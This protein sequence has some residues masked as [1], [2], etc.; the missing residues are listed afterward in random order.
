M[1]PGRISG[2]KDQPAKERFA[3]KLSA[4]E[5]QRG[6]QSESGGDGHGDG[7]N[8][9]AIQQRGPDGIV[10]EKG[11]IPAERPIARREAA[12]AAAVEGINGQ[13]DDREIEEG[14]NERGVDAEPERAR[15][16]GRIGNWRS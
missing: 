14:V 12:H 3:G 8:D 13:H 9:Q 4:V 11:A 2:Q 16:G 6:E 15:R 5:R 1:M 7:R 10:G